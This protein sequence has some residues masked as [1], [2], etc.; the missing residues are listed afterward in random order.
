MNKPSNEKI[1]QLTEEIAQLKGKLVCARCGFDNTKDDVKLDPELIKDYYKAML[2]QSLFE[3]EYTILNDTWRITC[4]EPNRKLISAYTHCWNN[5]D[6][7]IVQ[8]ALDLQCLLV[9]S[10]VEKI[11]ENGCT[12]VYS[13]NTEDRLNLLRSINTTNI[14]QQIP[15][16]YQE[17][18][19]V[20][21]LAI[22]NVSNMFNSLCLRLSDE[23]LNENFWKGVGLN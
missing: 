20:V 2:N 18:P 21:L 19:Q 9:I 4:T 10:K 7:T 5:L 14:E 6:D 23:A 16:F 12:T 8:Y 22:R 13:M 1:A 17:L 15:D 11:T 3:K